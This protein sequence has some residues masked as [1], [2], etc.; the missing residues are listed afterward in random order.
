MARRLTTLEEYRSLLAE[1]TSED[2]LLVVVETEL[3]LRGWRWHHVRRSDRAISQ[4]DPGWPD[5]VAIRRE[6]IVVAELK[7]QQGGHWEPGQRDWLDAFAAAGA[8]THTWRPAD[9]DTIRRTLA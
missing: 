8:E 5:I 7:R 1:S 9:L 4:G 6:R 3:T 2:E